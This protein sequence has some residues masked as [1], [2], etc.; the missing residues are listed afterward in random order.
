MGTCQPTRS[1]CNP[2]PVTA[3][4]RMVRSLL[5]AGTA[6]DDIRAMVGGNAARLLAR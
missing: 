4:R 6:A 2:L 1:T 3:Y 5:D